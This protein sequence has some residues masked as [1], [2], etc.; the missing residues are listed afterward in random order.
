MLYRMRNVNKAIYFR[1]VF[2]FLLAICV[3]DVILLV[4]NDTNFLVYECITIEMC[5]SIHF[6]QT[7]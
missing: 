3:L 4:N 2:S 6:G 5:T 1:G 7:F